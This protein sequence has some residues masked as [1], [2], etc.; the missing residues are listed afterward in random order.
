MPILFPTKNAGSPRAYPIPRGR[1]R[2]SKSPKGFRKGVSGLQRFGKWLTLSLVPVAPI[3]LST[4]CSTIQKMER[5]ATYFP[6]RDVLENPLFL[7]IAHKE[8]FIPTA[9]GQKLH[10]WFFPTSVSEKPARTILFFHGNGGNISY[11]LKQAVLFTEMGVQVFTIDYRGY[12]KSTGEPS[13]KG[14]YLDAEA[15]YRELTENQKIDPQDIIVYGH[16]LGAAVAIDL[17]S[18]VPVGKLIVESAFTNTRDVGKNLLPRSP[19]PYLVPVRFNNLKKV[20]GI[21]VPTLVIHGTED[22]MIPFSL[23]QELFKAMSNPKQFVAITGGDHNDNL[24]RE[25]DL[26]TSSIRSFLADFPR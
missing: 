13:E 1:Q 26:Y 3:A 25:G 6:T 18:K 11:C 8:I 4:G 9:D 23:A 17:V 15:A 14:L 2:S 10:S 19:L 5:N 7:G 21:R 22:S 16:S 20:K 24:L 12:G